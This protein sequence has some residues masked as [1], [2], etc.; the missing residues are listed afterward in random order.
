MGT[1]ND[2]LGFEELGGTGDTG[3]KVSQLWITGSVTSQSQISGLNVFAAGSVTD[4][5]GRLRSVGAGSPTVF[6]RSIQIG[7]AI[8]SDVSVLVAY[9]TA[10]TGI[11]RAVLTAAQSGTT[12]GQFNITS[13]T[14]TGFQFWGQ[15]GLA[16]NYIAIGI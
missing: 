12:S 15:S 1:L 6:G 10:F 7:S 4:G 13:G 3:S 8:A 16:Y 2:G 5:N 14:A 9:G 11:P